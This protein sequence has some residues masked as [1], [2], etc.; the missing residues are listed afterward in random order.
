MEP[1]TRRNRQKRI[2]DYLL[3]EKLGQGA[4]SSVFLAE[5]SKTGQK[6]AIKC[7]SK[8][9]LSES[10]RFKKQLNSEI[11]IMFN[12]KHPNVMRL[13]DLMESQNNYYLVLDYC[14]QGDFS[15]FMKKRKLQYLEESEAIY[16]LK[17]IMNGF[18]ELRKHKVIHRDFKLENIMMHNDTVKIGDFGMAKKG[19]EIAQTVAG[20]YLTM[21]PELLSSDGKNSYSAKCDLWS[22]GFVLYQILFGDV[23]F[24]GLSPFEIYQ[25][26]QERKNK[27]KFPKPVAS[28]TKDL[29]LHLLQ[30]DPDKR[31]DWPS[32]FKHPVFEVKFPKSMRELEII[33]QN[34]KTEREVDEESVDQEFGR[35]REEIQDNNFY[36]GQTSQERS[37]HNI[38][39]REVAEDL[40]MTINKKVETE[41]EAQ[42]REI[43]RRY[44]HEKN[45]ILFIIYSVRNVRPL[46]KVK[47]F[48]HLK[49][50]YYCIAVY[51][52]KKAITLSQ[53][54]YMSLINGNNIFEQDGFEEFLESSHLDGIVS[55]FKTDIPHFET[56]FKYLIEK[57]FKEN[58]ENKLKMI[59]ADFDEESFVLDEIDERVFNLF[60]ELRNRL[61][62]HREENELNLKFLAN[63][64][65][66]F[67]CINSE[68]FFPYK[69]KGEKFDWTSF[70]KVHESMTYF[71]LL[72][73]IK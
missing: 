71:E 42:K 69:I 28:Q 66:I 50:Y 48:D 59:L 54:N 36:N 16:Y 65:S 43:A 8:T 44:Y 31:L 11:G 25:D 52:L 68:R 62:D 14:N 6:F 58:M 39:V 12:I 26:I 34:K 17:Q 22:V 4:Q 30:P 23:P 7:Q 47:E 3:R 40:T 70:Y 15:Q 55:C 10:E 57:A 27:I 67:Y 19:H 20:S 18:K 35:N 9:Y 24:F 72:K 45:K 60:T 29:I 5:H 2:G 21:A 61:E 53:L 64:V 1:Q 49:S 51:L 32:F 73:V 56:Y 38:N 13:H 33:A 41:E 63:L 46:M 37:D